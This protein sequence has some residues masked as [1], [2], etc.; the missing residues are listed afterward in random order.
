MSVLTKAQI[1]K[2]EENAVLNGTFS[3][4][5]LMFTAGSLVAQKITEN[6]EV[7]T[8][9]IA[10]LVGKGNNGGDGCVI[11][12]LLS[13]SG[14]NVTV[15]TPLGA[16]VTENAKYYY[17]NLRVNITSKIEKDFD[18][19]IDALFGFGF[20]G[21]LDDNIKELIETANKQKGLK[22]K[23]IFILKTSPRMKKEHFRKV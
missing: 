2:A 21:K 11:A 4:K 18:I 19:I 22:I 10:V 5:D 20:Q 16:P 15:I 13:K 17:D 6:F 14:A 23:T 8:K 1:K 12:D 3:F 9:D 7:K